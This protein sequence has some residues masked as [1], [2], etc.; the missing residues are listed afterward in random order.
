MIYILKV[1]NELSVTYSRWF[2]WKFLELKSISI[3]IIAYGCLDLII[4]ISDSISLKI[5][6]E[7]N[8]VED[9]CWMSRPRKSDGSFKRIEFRALIIFW[10]VI[11]I[12]PEQLILIHTIRNTSFQ[13]SIISHN[14]IDE[15][16][17]W[18]IFYF[19]CSFLEE[20][21]LRPKFSQ[22]L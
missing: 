11:I 17:V 4:K 16:K 2:R 15:V 7:S 14:F 10:V 18:D 8:I 1:K 21:K 13:T 12:N 19:S 22:N 9:R 3:F 6:F 20:N 5:F